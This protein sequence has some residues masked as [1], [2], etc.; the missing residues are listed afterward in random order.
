MAAKG[1]FYEWGSW[2]LEVRN[3]CWM[4]DTYLY[5]DSA[6]DA[7]LLGE[8]GNLGGGR[9]FNAQLAHAD[10]GTGPL[11]LLSASLRLAFVRAD[12]GNSRLLVRL[13]G[14]LV[15][16]HGVLWGDVRGVT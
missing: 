12:D 15:L 4:G 1:H 14:R 6:T 16:R 9:H 11:A 7:E 2:L 3:S 13:L 5:A 8:D 10:Y